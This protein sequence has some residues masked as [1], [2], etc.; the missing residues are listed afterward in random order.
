MEITNTEIN[1]AGSGLPA[2]SCS[3]VEDAW[4]TYHGPMQIDGEDDYIP[5]VPPV[6]MRGFV[7]GYE[8]AKNMKISAGEGWN[9]I[10]SIPRDKNVWIYIK[11]QDLMC[12]S[13]YDEVVALGEYGEVTHWMLLPDSPQFQ[14]NVKA[15]PPAARK[16]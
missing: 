11:S 3:A 14:P 9:S 10:E 15:L 7:D 12:V 4:N 2:A 13:D 6:F 8:H 16:N 1:K 5:A